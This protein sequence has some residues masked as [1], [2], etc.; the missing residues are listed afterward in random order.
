MY[1]ANHI[2]QTL[3]YLVSFDTFFVN[4]KFKTSRP[5]FRT[6]VNQ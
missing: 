2:Y 5:G 4:S 1:I 6:P 3:I